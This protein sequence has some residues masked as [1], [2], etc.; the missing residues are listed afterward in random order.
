MRWFH[1]CCQVTRHLG[2]RQRRPLVPT[3]VWTCECIPRSRRSAPSVDP[4]PPST[5][6]SASSIIFS[7][8]S[9]RRLLYHHHLLLFS[10]LSSLLSSFSSSS[11]ATF[12]LFSLDTISLHREREC[13]FRVGAVLLVC[14]PSSQIAAAL[15]RLSRACLITLL[16][17]PLSP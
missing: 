6:F 9:L 1:T 10:T 3:R 2:P 15:H 16:S 7:F 14:A 11:S 12:C 17:T 4:S 13:V 8:F 5:F